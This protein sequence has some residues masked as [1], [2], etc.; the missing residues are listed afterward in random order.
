MRAEEI[1]EELF[2]TPEGRSDP[3][4][5]YHRLREVAPVH[6]SPALESWF[7][8]T[9]DGVAA[10]V[11]DPRFGK[12]YPRQM[13]IKF[14]PGWRDHSSLARGEDSMLNRSG[15]EH[16]RL[17]RL[18]IKAFTRRSIEALRPA[19]ERIMN[20]LLDPFSEKG[21]GDWMSEVAF[22]M[23]VAI[24]GELLGVP[25]EDREPFRSWV[26]DL[27]A[28]LEMRVDPDDLRKADIANDKIRAYFAELIAEKR[29]KPDDSLLSRLSNI[30]GAGDRLTDDEL[31]AMALVIF[32]AGFETTANLVGNGLFGLLQQ[33]DQMRTLRDRPELFASLP[34]ELLRFDGTAQMIVRDTQDDIE[35]GGVKIPK[36]QSVIGMLGAANRDPSEFAD[37]DRIDVTRGRFRPMGFGGGAHHCLGASLARAELEIA[38]R[39]LLERCD[40]I[41]FDGEPPPFRDRLTLR[42]LQVLPLAV[43]A[44]AKRRDLSVAAAEVPVAERAAARPAR[45][46]ASIPPTSARPSP[47]S[48]ADRVWRNE[49]RAQVEREDAS[50]VPT[51]SDLDSTIALLARAGL[52]QDCSPQEISALAATAY[53]MSFEVGDLLCEEGAE[54]LEC[55]VIE[56]GEAEVTIDGKFVRQV[57]ADD[58]VGERGPLEGHTRSATVRASSHM[59]TYAVSRQRLLELAESSASAREGMFAYM[60]ARYRD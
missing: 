27:L 51:G 45:P 31:S 16:A 41:E 57:E 60:K 43:R 22:P 35:V 37:P 26:V 34:D 52:F 4:P 32:A 30:Q 15:P 58:V 59:N 6:Y 28:T 14:G 20:E 54:S 42:G 48:D 36:Q 24:I 49:L 33:P 40:S 53:P 17:R 8:S 2:L 55:Y 25:K 3:Y 12:D 23:P 38:F 19:I 13:E 9:Y 56:E 46:M 11:R 39:T 10:M 21:G 50:F 18:V 1:V 47:G 7:V 44:G 29:S 5:R